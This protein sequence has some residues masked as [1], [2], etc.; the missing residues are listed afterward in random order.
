MIKTLSNRKLNHH[1]HLL[2]VLQQGSLPLSRMQGGMRGGPAP[3]QSWLS[4]PL[5]PCLVQLGFVCK[6]GRNQM[7]TTE[8]QVGPE[9]KPKG[10]LGGSLLSSWLLARPQA[11]VQGR[12]YRPL[13]LL[14]SSQ[15]PPAAFWLS[16]LPVLWSQVARQRR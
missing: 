7:E 3:Q 15:D 2:K 16:P 8:K 12:S 4:S 14:S 5:A 10:E 6:R 13:S 11:K 1:P 9:G